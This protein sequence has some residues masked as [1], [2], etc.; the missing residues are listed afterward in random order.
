[1]TVAHEEWGEERM[2][3]ATRAARNLEADC[4]VR[5]IFE[6]ADSFTNEAPQH[7][8]MTLLIMKVETA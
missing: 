8:D 6:A 7:D 5:K 1:M 4:I 3:E 2:I